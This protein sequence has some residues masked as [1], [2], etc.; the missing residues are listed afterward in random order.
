MLPGPGALQLLKEASCLVLALPCVGSALA[1]Q[2]QPKVGAT[3][4]A[5]CQSLPG[6]LGDGGAG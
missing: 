2:G 3:L 5:P 6:Q 1:G 4:P